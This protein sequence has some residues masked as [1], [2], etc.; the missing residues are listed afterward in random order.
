[1][2]MFRNPRLVPP[3]EYPHS[4]VRVIGPEPLS[5]DQIP[6]DPAA[7]LLPR[8]GRSDEGETKVPPP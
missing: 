3:P 7:D 5:L 8:Q 6:P 4:N 2:A 1:M